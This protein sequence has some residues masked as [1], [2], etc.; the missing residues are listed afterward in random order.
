MPFSNSRG[1]LTEAYTAT[2]T[3]RER[4]FG[5]T[6]GA[7]TTGVDDSYVAAHFEGIGAEIMGA[8][9]FGRRLDPRHLR[10]LGGHAMTTVRRLTRA[11]FTLT[12]DYPV[13]IKRV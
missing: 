13:P 12:R 2:R 1:R 11:D 5:D 9:M 7:G 8:A 4:I 10:A 3:F 6:S